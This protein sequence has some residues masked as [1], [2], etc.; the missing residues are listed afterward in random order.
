MKPTITTTETPV[1]QQIVQ[2]PTTKVDMR[3]EEVAAEKKLDV[4]IDVSL[5]TT[6]SK[7][8]V[9]GKSEDMSEKFVTEHQGF[10]LPCSPNGSPQLNQKFVSFVTSL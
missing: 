5:D 6:L 1:P 3:Q 9:K 8:N 2:V 7:L 4:P 10:S